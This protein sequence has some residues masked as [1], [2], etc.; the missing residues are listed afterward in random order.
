[1]ALSLKP[2]VMALVAERSGYGYDL[3]SR[4]EE[5]RFPW[6]ASTVY[7]ALDA[8][9]LEGHVVADHRSA[10]TARGPGRL[11]YSATDSGLRYV[12]DWMSEPCPWI[13]PRQELEIK[14]ALCSPASALALIAQIGGQE[15]F[16]LSELAALSKDGGLPGKDSGLPAD[17]PL[18]TWSEAG[19]LL[20]RDAQIKQL[21]ARIEHLQGARE[22]L[23]GLLKRTPKSV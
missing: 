10:P 15:Q 12:H 21:E 7:A 14:L 2:V 3:A 13:W 18:V 17:G 11:I 19:P 4:M 16:C 6:A 1:M 5:R 8:L 23:R 9:A 20:M 22:L